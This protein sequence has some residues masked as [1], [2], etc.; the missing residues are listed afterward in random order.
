MIRAR[1][2]VDGRLEGDLQVLYPEST[3]GVGIRGMLKA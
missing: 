2:R 3:E 1:I